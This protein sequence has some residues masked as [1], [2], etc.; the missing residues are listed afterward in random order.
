MNDPLAE[1]SHYYVKMGMVSVCVLHEDPKPDFSSGSKD[2]LTEKMRAVANEYF[3][4]VRAINF[5]GHNLL[6]RDIR[7][8]VSAALPLDHLGFVEF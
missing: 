1:I 6:L 5:S 4:C 8:K 2:S 3:R 7:D